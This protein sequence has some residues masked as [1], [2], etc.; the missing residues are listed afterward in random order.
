MS[1]HYI[2]IHLLGDPEFEPTQLLEALFAKLHRALAALAMTDLAITLP[3][4]DEA[5]LVLGTQVRLIAPPDSLQALMATPWL[6]G[7]R[8]HVRVGEATPVPESAQH[9]S[10]RRVQAKSNPERLRRRLIKRHGITEAQARDRIPDNAVEHL[11]LPSLAVRS[12]S[13]GQSFRL[14][15]RLGPPQPTPQPGP[16]N[17]YGLSTTATAPWF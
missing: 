10:L 15:L 13:T 16:F 1:S 17:A 7:M 11:R 14:Y 9:R 8:D 6:S 4:L 12:T 2:D 5:K 3:G